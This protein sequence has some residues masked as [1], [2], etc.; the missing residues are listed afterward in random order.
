MITVTIPRHF[1]A[2][3]KYTIDVLMGEMLGLDYRIEI[4]D[5]VDYELVEFIRSLKSAYKMGIISNAW[6]KVDELLER[7]EIS[8]AFDIVVGSGDVGVMKPD[9]R[10]YRLALEIQTNV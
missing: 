1:S 3:R 8:D 7:W 2:E 5:Q 6:P 9:P 4:K 10:I